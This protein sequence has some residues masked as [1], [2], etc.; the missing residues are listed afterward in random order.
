[1]HCKLGQVCERV[2]RQTKDPQ[3]PTL[4]TA[5]HSTRQSPAHIHRRPQL[6]LKEGTQLDKT[7]GNKALGGLCLMSHPVNL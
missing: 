4:E 7:P 5:Q 3:K 2:L 6:S 1:M